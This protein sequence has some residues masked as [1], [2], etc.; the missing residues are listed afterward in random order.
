M[1]KNITKP[2]IQK[3]KILCREVFP[4][5]DLYR[6]W[7]GE[8]FGVESCSPRRKPTRSNACNAR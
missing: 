3:I 6:A 1:P 5:D 4:S 2:Q 8:N 7:L